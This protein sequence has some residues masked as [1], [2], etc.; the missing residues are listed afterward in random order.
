VTVDAF[1][2]QNRVCITRSGMNDVEIDVATADLAQ[3]TVL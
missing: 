2:K 3:L 1:G